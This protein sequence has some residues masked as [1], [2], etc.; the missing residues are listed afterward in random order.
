MR[1][2]SRKSLIIFALMMFAGCVC[3]AHMTFSFSDCARVGDLMSD[4]VA[5]CGEPTQVNIGERKQV[6]EFFVPYHVRDGWLLQGPFI[7]EVP[8]D[9]EEWVYNLGRT[10][11][12]RI[13]RFENGIL[14]SIRNGGYGY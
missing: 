11:F 14:R 8:V 13:L 5:N 2:G 6:G 4:V 3:F 7:G 9:V 12:M 1:K 10:R